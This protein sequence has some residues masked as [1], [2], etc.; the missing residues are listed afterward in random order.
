[1]AEG[2]TLHIRESDGTSDKYRIITLRQRA[3]YDGILPA[4]NAWTPLPGSKTTKV[5]NKTKKTDLEKDMLER[6]K[7]W[8][9]TMQPHFSVRFDDE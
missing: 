3:T 6:S 9:Q 4:P 8:R 2:A 5:V 7:S 1:M